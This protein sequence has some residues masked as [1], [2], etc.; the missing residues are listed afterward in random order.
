MSYEH[1]V[2]SHRNQEKHHAGGGISKRDFEMLGYRSALN[3]FLFF[4]TDTL[5]YSK[6][7]SFS[8]LAICKFF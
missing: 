1:L 8:N 6:S 3:Q 5:C 7:L 2:I 4:S